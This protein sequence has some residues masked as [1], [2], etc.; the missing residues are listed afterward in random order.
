MGLYINPPHESKEDFLNNHAKLISRGEFFA[1]NFAAD[2][3]LV[4]VCLVDN[5][6]FKAAG[7]AFDYREVDAFVTEDHC[8]KKFYLIDKNLLTEDLAGITQ[9][10]LNTYMGQM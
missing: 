10:M 5:G 2:T 6:P 8:P 4:P 9:E 3:H 7:V 1:F